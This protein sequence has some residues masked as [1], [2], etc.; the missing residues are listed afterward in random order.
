MYRHPE[1]IIKVQ[2][3]LPDNLVCSVESWS[4]GPSSGASR[5]FIWEEISMAVSGE[6]QIIFFSLRLNCAMNYTRC[7]FKRYFLFN[8]GRLQFIIQLSHMQ[9][10]GTEVSQM[11]GIQAMAKQKQ[12]TDHKSK[13]NAG[14]T[15][16]PGGRDKG[17]EYKWSYGR[18][19]TE[20]TDQQK[21]EA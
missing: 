13:V 3:F 4:Q 9:K 10:T 18:L 12:R 11:R 16:G 19:R 14:S 8:L 15:W 17:T 20:Q 6:R 21:C 2:E 5:D 1:N 7:E